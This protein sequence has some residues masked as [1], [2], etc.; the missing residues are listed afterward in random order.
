MSTETPAVKLTPAQAAYLRA[1]INGQDAI[2]AYR[3]A[4]Q[5]RG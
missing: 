3:Q 1:V 5:L 2:E 4:K